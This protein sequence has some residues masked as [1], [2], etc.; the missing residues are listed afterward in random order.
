[1][2]L[3]TDRV[4]RLLNVLEAHRDDEGPLSRETIEAETG[5]SQR[6]IGR[7][8]KDLERRFIR[9]TQTDSESGRF[10][11]YRYQLTAPQSQSSSRLATPTDDEV[12]NLAAPPGQPAWLHEGEEVAN[13]HDSEVA[14]LHARARYVPRTDPPSGGTGLTVGLP[15]PANLEKA[16]PASYELRR[17]REDF[18]E[19]FR[20]REGR[21]PEADE[22]PD[23]LEALRAATT[24]PW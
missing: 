13:Q 20:Q 16:T 17:L 24:P 14:N 9:V 1:M 10:V 21:A 3:Q 6:T 23:D 7:A 12:A 11:G 4:Q 15:T 2:E 18:R 8:M 5:M 22:V 19:L